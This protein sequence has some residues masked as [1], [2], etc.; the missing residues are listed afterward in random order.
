MS[1]T[2]PVVRCEWGQKGLESLLGQTDVF[3]IIDVLSFTTSVDIAVSRGALVYPYIW[4]DVSSAEFAQAHG[5]SQAVSTRKAGFSLSP[6]SLTSIPAGTRLVLPSPNGST[7]SKMTAEV[8]TLAGCLRNARAVARAAR[9]LG[10]RI[11]VIAAGE[12]WKDQSLRLAIEDGLAA[13][14]IIAELEGENSAE[15]ELARLGFIAARE[16]LE[17][18]LENSLSG[19]ELIERGRREDIRLAGAWNVSDC[20]PLLREGAFYPFSS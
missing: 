14:A 15:A 18:Y 10:E 2:R 3:V 6:S 13:G 4:N 7:L 19:Q 20:A 12:R 1:Q 17:W 11:S 5:A 8:P 16:R 9:R